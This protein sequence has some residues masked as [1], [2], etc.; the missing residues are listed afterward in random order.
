MAKGYLPFFVLSMLAMAIALMIPRITRA[1][2]AE[3]P[4]LEQ[5]TAKMQETYDATQDLTAK[6]VQELTLAS[7]KKTDREEGTFYFKNPGRM[8]WEYTRP[9]SKKLV[10]NPQKAWLYVP[11]DRVVYVHDAKA[12]YRSKLIIRFLSG[13]GKF[14]DDFRI[15]YAAPTALDQQGNYL[16]VLTPK[17]GDLGVDRLHI[18]VDRSSLQI[19]QCHFSDA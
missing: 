16:L 4:P 7:I 10:V 17:Q 19:V 1:G 3:T 6:F 8:C 13:I 12:M 5:L 15:A 2:A 9:K 11:E 18:T 14:R